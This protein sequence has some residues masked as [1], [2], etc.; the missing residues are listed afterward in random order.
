[1][2]KNFIDISQMQKTIKE[3][4]LLLVVIA[5]ELATLNSLY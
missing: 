3:K 5:Y 1:M 4:F 2:F